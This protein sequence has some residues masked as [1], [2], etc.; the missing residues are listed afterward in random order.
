[1]KTTGF[2]VFAGLHRELLARLYAFDA[3]L[4]V[5]ALAY[6]IMPVSILA[7][8]LSNLVFLFLVM[9][10][11]MLYQ[12]HLV[13]TYCG[14]AAF[15][16]NLPVRRR[17]W[18]SAAFLALLA[19]GTIGLVACIAFL[20]VACGTSGMSGEILGR[21]QHVLIVFI[22][23]KALPLPTFLKFRRHPALVVL[24]YMQIGLIQV[25]LMIAQELFFSR[26][27]NPRPFMTALF[28]V[29]TL[30]FCFRVVN[31]ARLE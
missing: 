7:V 16:L 29:G 2:L 4:I 31:R 25:V 6:L 14:D 15:Y 12:L 28:I 21:G 22:L 30:L 27:A 20:S 10:S 24:L 13:R 9:I 18:V 8:S 1:M 5:C 3:L 19:P 23:L 26:L 11:C 17:D